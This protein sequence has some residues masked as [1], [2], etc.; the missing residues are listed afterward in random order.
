[1]GERE[2]LAERLRKWANM[3]AATRELTRDNARR[4]ATLLTEGPRQA[5]LAASLASEKA[6][7]A[8]LEHAPCALM[9][10]VGY[11]ATRHAADQNWPSCRSCEALAAYRKRQG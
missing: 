8:A 11:C 3:P 4:A 2:E 9:S 5:E 1:M 10:S 6:L 7:A